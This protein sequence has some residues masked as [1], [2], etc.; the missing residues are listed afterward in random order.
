[1]VCP[2]VKSSALHPIC[3]AKIPNGRMDVAEV[4][5]DVEPAAGASMAD[6]TA[7]DRR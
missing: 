7:D 6:G 1:M 3:M 5:M 4:P 2:F